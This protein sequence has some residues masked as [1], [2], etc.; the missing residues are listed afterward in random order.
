MYFLSHNLNRR[1]NISMRHPHPFAFQMEC[2]CTDMI[3]TRVT[4]EQSFCDRNME[5]INYFIHSV[6]R[7][8]AGHFWRGKSAVPRDD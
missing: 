6:E 5:D 2:N 3:E 7:V 4:I 1:S 8:Y